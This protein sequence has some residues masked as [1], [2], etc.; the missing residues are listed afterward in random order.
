[1]GAHGAHNLFGDWVRPLASED[2]RVSLEAIGRIAR[3]CA[4][5]I[6]NIAHTWRDH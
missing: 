5:A 3:R 6:P 1:M 2:L 4:H